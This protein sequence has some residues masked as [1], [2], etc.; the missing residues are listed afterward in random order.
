MGKDLFWMNP[1][2]VVLIFIGLSCSIEIEQMPCLAMGPG[3]YRGFCDAGRPGME[4]HPLNNF[5]I[6][7][8]DLNSGTGR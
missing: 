8:R 4:G 7:I 5:H 3:I 1:G 6:F 2:A